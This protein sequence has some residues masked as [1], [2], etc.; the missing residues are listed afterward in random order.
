M[1]LAGEFYPEV[2]QGPLGPTPASSQAQSLSGSFTPLWL[3]GAFSSGAQTRSWTPAAASSDPAADM[4][5]GLGP[6]GQPPWSSFLIYTLEK[7][8]PSGRGLL[9]RSSEAHGHPTWHREGTWVLTIAGPLSR[10]LHGVLSL[11][12][13]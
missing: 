13:L 9:C 4:P 6:T 5:C 1:T 2:K 11:V 8:G 12:H 10:V 7:T 3:G